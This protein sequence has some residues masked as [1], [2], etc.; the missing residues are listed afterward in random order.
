MPEFAYPNLLYCCFLSR[1]GILS[2]NG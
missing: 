2:E 1:I